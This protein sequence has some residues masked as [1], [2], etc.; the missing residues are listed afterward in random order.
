MERN[1]LTDMELLWAIVDFKNLISFICIIRKRNT[2]IDR[3]WFECQQVTKK[4]EKKDR[5]S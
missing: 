1:R 2:G 4:K 5:M 3:I